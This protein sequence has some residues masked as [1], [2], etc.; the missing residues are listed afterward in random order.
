L[1]SETGGETAAIL[2]TFCATCRKL[3]I[4]AQEYLSDVLTTNQHPP[5]VKD[6]R[7][8]PGPLESAPSASKQAYQKLIRFARRVGLTLTA[9]FPNLP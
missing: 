2:M 9:L 3:K 5:D 1:G 4:N 7:T 6:R 8:P